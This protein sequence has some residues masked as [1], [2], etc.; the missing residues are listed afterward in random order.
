M[1]LFLWIF[2]EIISNF[3]YGCYITHEMVVKEVRRLPIWSTKIGNCN[4]NNYKHSKN[5]TFHWPNSVKNLESS[6]WSMMTWDV[7][8]LIQWP[9]DQMDK[10]N[11]FGDLTIF[12][13]QLNLLWTKCYDTQRLITQRFKCVIFT[14]CEYFLKTPI[15]SRDFKN[16]TIV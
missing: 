4:F 13:M 3:F 5:L 2:N 11:R 12:V 6:R 16:I 9:T 8:W 7:Y 15:I 1:L 10:Y 14:Q